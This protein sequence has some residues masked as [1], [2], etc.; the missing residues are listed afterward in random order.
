M[1]MWRRRDDWVGSQVDD[2][3]VMI[4][5]DSGEY[6]ALN[7]TAA[8]VWTL[9]EEPRDADGLVEA[10]MAKFDVERDH[11]RK[12]V[13]GLLAHLQEKKLAEPLG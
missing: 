3:Y 10:L 1:T 4:N 2:R 11:C 6:V 8:E 9:L 12:S 7:A 13:D 5:L